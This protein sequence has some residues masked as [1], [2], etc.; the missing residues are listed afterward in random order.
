MSDQT[1]DSSDS[2][3]FA[4]ICEVLGFDRGLSRASPQALARVGGRSL[5]DLLV[6]SRRVKARLG[7]RPVQIRETTVE[8]V[9]AIKEWNDLNQFHETM[10]IPALVAGL[11]VEEG[12]IT[13]F[14]D[15]LRKEHG[16][17]LSGAIANASLIGRYISM[18][19]AISSTASKVARERIVFDEKVD[20]IELAVEALVGINAVVAAHNAKPIE[21]MLYNCLQACIQ[22]ET[23]DGFNKHADRLGTIVIDELR[24]IGPNL[25]RYVESNDFQLRR[26]ELSGDTVQEQDLLMN[27]ADIL[28]FWGAIADET[29]RDRA[30]E[31]CLGLYDAALALVE[32]YRSRAPLV[33]SRYADAYLRKARFLFESGGVANREE[34]LSC[35]TI[36]TRLLSRITAAQGDL[37]TG[38]VN[39]IPLKLKELQFAMLA[40]EVDTSIV[41]L[42]PLAVSKILELADYG[43]R[44]RVTQPW[45][46]FC[47]IF[48]QLYDEREKGAQILLEYLAKPRPPIAVRRATKA[49]ERLRPIRGVDAV[50]SSMSD[51]GWLERLRA[52]PRSILAFSLALIGYDSEGFGPNGTTPDLV[53]DVDFPN[54]GYGVLFKR[55]VKFDSLIKQRLINEVNCRAALVESSLPSFFQ[56]AFGLEE[57]VGMEELSKFL[58]RRGKS[59]L[60]EGDLLVCAELLSIGLQFSD[61]AYWYGR[62]IDALRCLKKYELAWE[63][64]V[65]AQAKFP[66]DSQIATQAAL[67]QVGRGDFEQAAT[68]LTI[69]VSDA[70]RELGSYHPAVQGLYAYSLMRSDRG[71]VA[72]RIYRGMVSSRPG[73]WR[74]KHGLGCLLYRRGA[75]FFPEAL[76]LWTSVVLLRDEGGGG[77]QDWIARDCTLNIAQT[78]KELRSRGPTG[79]AALVAYFDEIG[80]TLPTPKLV[81]VMSGLMICG[82]VQEYVLQLSRHVEA[83][84]D[85][86]LLKRFAQCCMSMIIEDVIKGRHVPYVRQVVGFAMKHKVLGDLFGGAKGSYTR[87][88]MRISATPIVER[89]LAANWLDT[90]TKPIGANWM[91]LIDCVSQDSYVP[92]YYDAVY[93]RVRFA[94]DREQAEVEEMLQ[95]AVLWTAKTMQPFVD[96][97]KIIL[98]GSY[99]RSFSPIFED[100]ISVDL[101]RNIYNCDPDN[102]RAVLQHFENLG[103]RRTTDELTSWELRGTIDN[104]MQHALRTSNIQTEVIGNDAFVAS[105]GSSAIYMDG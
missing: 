48:S 25:L 57:S 23:I 27:A 59:R 49:L 53:M 17:L 83:R 33:V 91:A 104:E 74:A 71:Q 35:C 20:L 100:P 103:E 55:L 90:K 1:P 56:E 93:E 84:K 7:A 77:F 67:V 92:D 19:D 94:Y 76:R 41:E 70:G 105:V 88:L 65:Q 89:K 5:V 4:E 54:L 50:V 72:E 36:G 63:A 22:V 73:D 62:L 13:K 43:D 97:R 12:P 34:I 15:L 40:M 60:Q 98:S 28:K 24:R 101:D 64:A 16:L 21:G 6:D 42:I 51:Y 82:G 45:I 99:P 14:V 26:K 95:L 10:A 3:I 68:T 80:E 44:L 66:A 39:L 18:A 81:D 78:A 79:T 11:K 46:L 8:L 69:F 102:L 30:F 75:D 96:R 9:R 52:S 29:Y 61:D 2:N 31:A 85:G 86:R 32:A 37:R 47:R 38:D 87:N 58:L